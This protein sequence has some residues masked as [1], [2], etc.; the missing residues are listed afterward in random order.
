[1]KNKKELRLNKIPLKLFLEALADIYN[2]GVEYVDIIGSPGE[3]QDSIGLAIKKEYFSEP[4]EEEEE[5][6]DL[7]EEDL[8][9]LI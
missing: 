2:R 8:N 6:K 4:E 3:E 5:K 1:M 7:S 9:Q